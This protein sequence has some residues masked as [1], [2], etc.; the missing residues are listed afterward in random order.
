MP[1]V[2]QIIARVIDLLGARGWAFS[3]TE[4][5]GE[6]AVMDTDSGLDV[7]LVLPLAP[8]GTYVG[9]L[10]ADYLPHEAL[11]GVGVGAVEEELAAHVVDQLAPLLSGTGPGLLTEV[12]IRAEGSGSAIYVLR[13]LRAAVGGPSA[14]G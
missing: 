11:D 12:G 13:A 9:G 8:V 5:D 7:M 3:P 4:A 2:E 1:N 6:W 14:E 10:I